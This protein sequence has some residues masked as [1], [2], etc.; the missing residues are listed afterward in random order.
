M[1]SEATI[2]ILIQSK[3]LEAIFYS[4]LFLMLAM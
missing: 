4:D 2:Y 3:N 1:A